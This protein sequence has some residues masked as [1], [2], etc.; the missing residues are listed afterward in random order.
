[1]TTFDWLAII[2]G[3]AHGYSSYSLSL[4]TVQFSMYIHVSEEDGEVKIARTTYIER[5]WVVVSQWYY[6]MAT[7]NQHPPVHH[8]PLDACYDSVVDG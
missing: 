2:I 1:M 5:V 7:M 6:N 3:L 4:Y 8:H